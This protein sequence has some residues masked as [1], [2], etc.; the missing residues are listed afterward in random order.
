MELFA[1]FGNKEEGTIFTPTLTL[2]PQG[3]GEKIGGGICG[4]KTANLVATRVDEI[5]YIRQAGFFP[6]TQHCPD[7]GQGGHLFRGP[8]GITA[9]D[10]NGRRGVLSGQAAHG[11]AGLLVGPGGNGAGVHQDKMRRLFLRRRGPAPGRQVLEQPGAVTLVDL[12]AESDEAES[13]QEITFISLM[14]AKQELRQK[15][16]FPSGSLGTSHS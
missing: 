15:F 11:L 8:L 2:P 6:I 3:G 16:A 13:G 10:K 12:T 14:A 4:W 9:G 7:A 5:N 1:W